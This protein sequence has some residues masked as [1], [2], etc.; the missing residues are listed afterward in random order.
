[1]T[2]TG[3]GEPRSA[4][5]IGAVA[6]GIALLLNSDALFDG[7][8]NTDSGPD[9]GA[10]NRKASPR[11][12]LPT[13][14]PA[15]LVKQ[16]APKVEVPGLRETL[17]GP[18]LERSGATPRRQVRTTARSGTA[19]SGSFARPS[20]PAPAASVL[21]PAQAGAA[22]SELAAIASPVFPSPAFGPAAAAA[23]TTDAAADTGA[24][25]QAPPPL[26]PAP[27]LAVAPLAR[28]AAFSTLDPGAAGVAGNEALA[29]APTSPPAT[30]FTP[31]MAAPDP[32]AGQDGLVAGSS[33][34]GSALIVP[35]PL[36]VAQPGAAAVPSQGSVEPPAPSPP[37]QPGLATIA[38]AGVDGAPSEPGPAQ[39]AKAVPD[40]S[41]TE[42]S[43]SS[44]LDGPPALAA[45][46]PEPVF[47]AP[48]AGASPIEAPGPAPAEATEGS[49]AQDPAGLALPGLATPAASLP[50]PGETGELASHTPPSRIQAAGGAPPTFS[51]DDE[52]ILEVRLANG[53][54]AD[55]IVA[56]GTRS[57][58]YLPL[59]A[60][61][62]M[63]DLAIVVSDSGNYASGWFLDEKRTLTID[64]RQARLELLGKEMPFPRGLIV[65]LN[66]DMYVRDDLLGE[67][68]PMTLATDLR[69]QS[70]VI[71]TRE[72]FPFEARM[73]REEQRR[74]LNNQSA[75]SMTE[76]F[77]RERTP[78]RLL[79]FPLVDAEL[80]GVSDDIYGTRAEADVRLST[81]LAFMSVESFTSATTRDGLTAARLEFGRQ[82]PY[83]ELLGPMKATEFRF[84]DVSTQSLPIGLRGVSGRGTF[85]TNA[86]LQQVSIFERID[87]RGELPAG[88]EVELYR[89]NILIGSTQEAIN[90]Q[91]EFLQIPVEFGL[92]VM[93]LVFYG[94]QGQRREEVRRF[95]VGDGRLA[96]GELVY[97]FGAAQKDRNLFGVY[98]PNFR[99]QRDFG[100]WRSTAQ[101]SYG[102]SSGLTGNLSA[103][104]FEALDGKTRQ[105]FGAG[106]RTG[107]LGIGAKLD[108]AVQDGGGK[109]IQFGLGGRVLGTAATL[110]H[111]E[112]NGP[113][114]DDIR[115]FGGSYLR[116]ATEL[117]VN[118]SIG[119]GG[120]S[121]ARLPYA[122]RVKRL[123]FADGRN[124]LEA[125]LRGSA[126]FGTVLAS[127]VFDFQTVTSPGSPR[128][129]QLRGSFD[130]ASHVGSSTQVRGALGYGILP[131]P[132]LQTV[133]AQIDHALD[134]RTLI[135]ASAGHGFDNKDTFLGLSATRK[136]DR[137][138][139]GFDSHLNLPSKA[140][141]VALRLGFS[142]GRNPVTSKPFIDQPGLA[143]SGAVA[144]R[145][146]HDRD[147]DGLYG[148]GEEPLP[149]VQFSTGSQTKTTDAA[150]VALI[151]NLTVGSRTVLQIDPDSLPDITLAPRQ[152]GLEIAPRPGRIHALDF[153]VVDVSEVTGT[154]Y[155]DKPGERRPVAGIR[156]E[157][158]DAEQKVVAQAK[159]EGDGYFFFEQVMPGQYQV[160]IDPEQKQR[161]GI[162]LKTEM[163]IEI[164]PG[165]SP[166][167]MELTI[168]KPE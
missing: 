166:P 115:E 16:Q 30:A 141:G 38:P 165:K 100:N 162:A 40:A 160:R 45:K 47:G 18:R 72:T 144:V 163:S 148:N 25:A 51:A 105:Q 90:G 23:P 88:H 126:R 123:E 137:F 93:R 17:L 110:T 143:A 39:L 133:N 60:L 69:D 139:L 127:N 106:L 42:H 83:A 111:A 124:Q 71:T 97:A 131:S 61:A 156:F 7:E 73:A 32:P 99:P 91:F 63:L 120:S 152:R 9:P 77:V 94:P 117:D 68:L 49:P 22:S 4:I 33:P 146:F 19:L 129:T 28:E 64:L 164:K 79:D 50:R 66:D 119:L 128:N 11:L 168:S 116:R 167:A 27:D 15:P 101:V 6:V 140:Y 136:F 58:V 96:A 86:P 113:F 56:Y 132:K 138:T 67:L 122:A 161:Y 92:N 74:R 158:V 84:G 70:I 62:R 13:F 112:Y 48:A 44:G 12:P 149:E 157:L 125:S 2:S 145:A 104:V 36:A 41:P 75:A 55:T 8:P 150:G 147:G 53:L 1:M 82:D 109:A 34:T 76:V 37:P 103:A 78:W 151:G 85:L 153:P 154:A 24:L 107:V 130:L 46:F 98:T 142:F 80:R 108:L 121:N 5:R 118:G 21:N 31:G 89:N 155:F 26:P 59:G 54:V 10:A 102:I 134:D 3:G 95:M 65:A 114:F 135:S 52:L 57:G 14:G 159:S 81:D 20:D 29:T 87:L 35:A 43:V